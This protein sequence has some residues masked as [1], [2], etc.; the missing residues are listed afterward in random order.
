MVASNCIISKAAD[1]EAVTGIEGHPDV[2]VYPLLRAAEGSL[3]LT[4]ALDD[5]EPGGGIDPHFHKDCAVFDHAYYVISG[6]ILV[7]VG[8]QEQRVG[9]DTL[10][11]HPSSEIHSIKNVGSDTA[12]VLLINAI[13]QEETRGTPV[14]LK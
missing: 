10:I 2:T 11:Y 7:S 9:A 12:K 13:A 8:G 5:I 14:Y 4:V 3:Q 6:D 1:I